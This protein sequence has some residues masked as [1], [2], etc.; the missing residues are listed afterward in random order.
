LPDKWHKCG[1]PKCQ[2]WVYGTY[3]RCIK[4]WKEFSGEYNFPTYPKDF[5][6]PEGDVPNWYKGWKKANIPYMRPM[7]V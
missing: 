7:K 1:E 4:C 5:P 3:W 6:K 2:N